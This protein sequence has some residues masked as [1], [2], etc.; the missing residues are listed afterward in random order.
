MRILLFATKIRVSLIHQQQSSN[1]QLLPIQIRI[2]ANKHRT[3]D[4]DTFAMASPPLHEKLRWVKIGGYL[5]ALGLAIKFI[6]GLWRPDA[7]SYYRDEIMDTARDILPKV[8]TA[9]QVDNA[10]HSRMK[11][12]DSSDRKVRGIV[13]WLWLGYGLPKPFFIAR[14]AY[15]YF[16]VEDSFHS[17]IQES[18]LEQWATPICIV[19]ALMLYLVFNPL[20]R[21]DLGFLRY[22]LAHP[23]YAL[24]PSAE[25]YHYTPE[26]MVRL[27]DQEEVETV[28][29]KLADIEETPK[30]KPAA[31]EFETFPSTEKI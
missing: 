26:G 24:F 6:V 28:E 8:L 5:Y 9:A 19:S 25:K 4:I 3:P 30:A 14:A 23:W 29:K 15:S 13:P 31:T 21:A 18:L 20:G 10:Y 17:S 16:V 22:A 12:R 11:W 1:F 2:A 27:N 7:A